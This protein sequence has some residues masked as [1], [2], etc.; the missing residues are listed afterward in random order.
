MGAKGD[1]GA[2]RDR[3]AG[4]TDRRD[5]YWDSARALLMLLGIPYHA[6]LAYKPGQEWIVVSG[7]GA[8]F[9]TYLSEFIHLFR[10]PAFFMIA[11]YFA[12]LLLARREP[13]VWLRARLVRL[14]VP[15]VAAMLLLVPLMNFVTELSNLPLTQAVASFQHNSATSGGYWVRHLWFIIILL[16]CSIAVATVAWRRPALRTALVG[17]RLDGWIAR[18]FPVV[19][20][21]MAILLGLWEAGAVELFYKAGLATNL[22]QQVLRLDELI[23]FAPWFLLG[24]LIQRAPATLER[25]TRPSRAVAMVAVVA[26]GVSLWTLGQLSPPMGRFVGTV[27]GTALAQMVFAGA[28][29][30]LDRPIPLVQRLVSASFVIYLFHMP[31]IVTLIWLGQTVAV[32]VGVKAVAVMLLGLGLSYGVWLLVERSPLLSFLFD[33]Q[34]RRAAPTMRI[35]TEARAA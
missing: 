21:A 31:I 7:E 16:Y 19:L 25:M 13:D 14:F 32:P 35:R 27:A 24:C 22:P 17:P 3:G 23:M 11:G 18:N 10:M 28:R 1:H 8:S 4:R 12:A 15:L 20:L 33:G 2:A 29:A 9:F 5:H 30:F 6:A 34:F 26:T